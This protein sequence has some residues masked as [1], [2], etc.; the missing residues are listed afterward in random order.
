MSDGESEID[1][2]VHPD[3]RENPLDEVSLTAAI[4]GL[5]CGVSIT[6]LPYFRFKTLNLYLGFLA[7]FHFLEYYVTARYNADKVVADSFLLYSNGLAYTAAHACA[8]AEAMIEH[9]F[10]PQFKISH[11][12]VTTIGFVL[13]VA[14]QVLRYQA[15]ATA[16]RSFSHLIAVEKKNSHTLVTDGVYRFSRH[17]SYAGFYWWA[18]GTQLMLLNPVCLAGFAVVLWRFFNRRIEVEERYLVQFFGQRY[19]VFKKSTG[20]LIPFV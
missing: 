16:G 11:P 7:V 2:D 19:N 8:L 20:T 4:L 15:M 18:I 9:Y 13:V 17:P 14:G 1:L 6:L 3:I 12:Y 5:V 10:F